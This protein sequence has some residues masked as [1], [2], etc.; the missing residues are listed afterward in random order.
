MALLPPRL[1]P[2]GAWVK[3]FWDGF[4]ISE[5][6]AESLVEDLQ[7]WGFDKS[8]ARAVVVDLLR[9]IDIGKRTGIE[10][11]SETNITFELGY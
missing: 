11:V 9:S 6:S 7:K 5:S 1:L 10:L 8:L 2:T 4:H 3:I